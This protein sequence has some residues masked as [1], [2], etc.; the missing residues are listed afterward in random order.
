[1]ERRAVTSSNIKSVGY[2][3]TRLL[4]EIEFCGDPGPVYQYGGVPEHLYL[5]LMGAESKG[6]YFREQIR[7]RFPVRQV[8]SDG[9]GTE[10]PS[11]AAAI[12]TTR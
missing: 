3:R 5:N 6:R 2:D 11:T 1:V 7:D 9:P 12:P 8:S 10:Q 4:L